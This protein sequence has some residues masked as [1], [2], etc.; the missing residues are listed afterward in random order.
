M[1]TNIKLC[2]EEVE[3]KKTLGRYGKEMVK[4]NHDN[5]KVMLNWLMQEDTYPSYEEYKEAFLEQ[6]KNRQW[7][8]E[9]RTEGAIQY[10]WKHQAGK[11]NQQRN[12]KPFQN[13]SE[14]S[15]SSH[16][17]HSTSPITPISLHKSSSETTENTR[18]TPEAPRESQRNT[19]TT[20]NS[21]TTEKQQI[22]ELLNEHKEVLEEQIKSYEGF[23]SYKEVYLNELFTLFKT[24]HPNL[25]Y[26]DKS[27]RHNFIT[28]IYDF[29]R[30]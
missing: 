3:Y 11:W 18:E 19:E 25:V 17:S 2:H 16:P 24:K 7:T 30:H 4:Q 5:L 27:L 26:N 20:E 13:T 14:H 10:L 28:C 8:P 12:L 21:E 29:Y 1:R 6:G 9:A 22:I 23:C 15:I